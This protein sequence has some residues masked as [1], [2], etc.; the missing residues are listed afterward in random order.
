M[1]IRQAVV[2]GSGVGHLQAFQYL[3]TALTIKR[4]RFYAV[5]SGWRERTS[6]IL[7]QQGHR[8][9]PTGCG[10]QKWSR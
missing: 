3:G 7:P 4:V 8:Q 10:G 9:V 5:L 6:H 2:G 1:Q